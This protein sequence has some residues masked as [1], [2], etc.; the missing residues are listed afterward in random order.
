MTNIGRPSKVRTLDYADEISEL[1][2][3]GYSYEK[4]ARIM[5]SRYPNNPTISKDVVHRHLTGLTKKTLK[6]EIVTIQQLIG[7][8]FQEFYYKLKTL[9][10]DSKERSAIISYMKSKERMLKSKTYEYYAGHDKPYTE[11]QK[12]REFVL[13]FSNC[14]C[15]DC[16][17]KLVQEV[18]EIEANNDRIE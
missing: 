12:V 17:R 13:D 10:I 14:L 15:A 1:R 18:L 2:S 8:T 11:Y 16:R 9:T 5:N 3:E 6:P 7:D 4:I